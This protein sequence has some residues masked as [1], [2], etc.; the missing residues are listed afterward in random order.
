MIYFIKRSVHQST[1]K[2][3]EFKSARNQTQG[4]EFYGVGNNR[5]FFNAVVPC[6]LRKGAYA[7]QNKNT[8]HYNF[9]HEHRIKST[10]YVRTNAFYTFVQII[11]DAI[12]NPIYIYVLKWQKL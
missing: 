1:R 4:I 8:N 10:N 6:I 12:Q 2:S 9:T 5:K 11:D 3:A 7:E